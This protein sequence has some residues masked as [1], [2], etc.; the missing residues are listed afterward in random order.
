M[1]NWDLLGIEPTKDTK[2]IKKAYAKQL[3]K[4]HPEDDP[5]GYQELRLTYDNAML[6]AKEEEEKYYSHPTGEENDQPT[7]VDLSV[8]EEEQTH[9]V[10][11]QDWKDLFVSLFEDI[12]RRM[13]IKE[14][15][16]IVENDTM[17]HVDHF[18]RYKQMVMSYV[19]GRPYL[20][21]EVWTFISE[22]FA[23]SKEEESDWVTRYIIQHPRFDFLS[24]LA[25]SNL[26]HELYFDLRH[27]ARE[28]LMRK[29]A[30]LAYQQSK[31]ALSYY[32]DD[33][34]LLYL[35]AMICQHLLKWEEALTVYD[36]I[37]T[38][39]PNHLSSKVERVKVY[40]RL[41]Q[42][43]KVIDESVTMSEEQLDRGLRILLAKSYFKVGQQ[44]EAKEILDIII[45][46][47][48]NDLEAILLLEQLRAKRKNPIPLKLR[49]QYT[50]R[51]FFSFKVV[52]LLILILTFHSPLINEIER[53]TGHSFINWIKHGFQSKDAVWVE[54]I[55]ELLET[56][57]QPNTVIVVTLENVEE[58]G[59]YRIEK[60]NDGQ[61]NI[62]FVTT[63]QVDGVYNDL[64]AEMVFTGQLDNYIVPF[65]HV[66]PFYYTNEDG[67]ELVDLIAEWDVYPESGKYY[68]EN[69][70]SG[71]DDSE[72]AT[73]LE[74]DLMDQDRTKIEH[75]NITLGDHYL[76]GKIGLSPHLISKPMPFYVYLFLIFYVIALYYL[77]SRLVRRIRVFL[78]R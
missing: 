75:E 4:Y 2:E 73:L 45:E 67:Q 31:E 6:Y 53:Y 19:L 56:R 33:I 48:K 71:T 18:P 13:D 25:V 43:K 23:W 76:V 14:W 35:H 60:E 27:E 17:W 49:L 15:K 38:K 30:E 65:A 34:D 28:A 12:H 16:R 44:K 1:I 40:Y 47:D 22:I 11:E 74:G 52:L 59:L 69:Y 50:I 72:F 54:S 64:T 55:D 62:S 42:W 24:V 32:A 39:E 61:K 51:S 3:T 5:T 70:L 57:G 26:D 20:P 21:Y 10:E 37:L 41:D 9:Y 58:T 77:I 78:G 36:K 63:S 66:Y 7:S 68:L 29:D 46:K 8:L